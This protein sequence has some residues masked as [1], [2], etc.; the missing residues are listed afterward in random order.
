M[1]IGN[2]SGLDNSANLRNDVKRV[3]ENILPSELLADTQVSQKLELAW[4]EEQE[5]ENILSH[6]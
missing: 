4:I 1:L 2:D 6:H 3:T 5:S